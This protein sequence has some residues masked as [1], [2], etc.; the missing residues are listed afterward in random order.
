MTSK[1][2]EDIFL[3][4]LNVGFLFVIT[5]DSMQKIQKFCPRGMW[6][7][8]CE[9]TKI[10][11]KLHI[12]YFVKLT[13]KEN[14]SMRPLLSEIS[15]FQLKCHGARSRQARCKN[16]YA[17]SRLDKRVKNKKRCC[18]FSRNRTPTLQIKYLNYWMSAVVII[19]K[20]TKTKLPFGACSVP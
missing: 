14:R 13:K 15:R 10:S 2:S 8:I 6:N 7:Y 5:V 18:Y 3:Y 19:K 20:L 16:A 1:R 4:F 9:S 11:I 12:F 17:I